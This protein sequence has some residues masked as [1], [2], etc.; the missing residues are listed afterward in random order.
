MWAQSSEAI[1]AWFII[2]P[3]YKKLYK[4][5]LYIVDLDLPESLTNAPNS[6]QFNAQDNI[7]GLVLDSHYSM[8]GS[9]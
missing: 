5:F 4:C 7:M 1:T 8:E 2:G 3:I 6:I 9:F